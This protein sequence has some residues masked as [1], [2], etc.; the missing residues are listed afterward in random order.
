MN[1][2]RQLRRAGRRDGRATPRV[3]VDV[4]P[5]PAYEIA[6]TILIAGVVGGSIAW[7]R[8]RRWAR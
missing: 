7:W 3:L 6:R 2:A 8:A 5:V 4:E 1:A